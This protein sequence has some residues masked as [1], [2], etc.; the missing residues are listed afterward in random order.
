[1]FQDRC[2]KPLCHAS[3]GGY[4]I[5]KNTTWQI[6]FNKN[7]LNVQNKHNMGI[8]SHVEYLVESFT[9]KIGHFTHT[10]HKKQLF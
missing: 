6:I 10:K 4:H 9:S 2:I 8:F 3:N 5:N 1:G 7:Q